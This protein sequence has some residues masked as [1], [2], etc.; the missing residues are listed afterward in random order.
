MLPL[1]NPTN[2]ELRRLV[3]CR[4][5][6]QVTTLADIKSVDGK[7]IMLQ[8]WHGKLYKRKVYSYS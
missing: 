1:S 4:E 8:V 7:K 6:L 3:E 5:Y 2:N